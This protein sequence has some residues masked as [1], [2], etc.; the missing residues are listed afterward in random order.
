LQTFSRLEVWEGDAAFLA[1][2]ARARASSR[3]GQDFRLIEFLKADL[4]ICHNPSIP[5]ALLRS[6]AP[7]RYDLEGARQ[8][9]RITL[10]VAEILVVY[11]VVDFFL[12]LFYLEL[13]HLAGCSH[14]V[15]LVNLFDASFGD[16]L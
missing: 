6:G 16:F 3:P 2:T 5:R 15:S 7:L 11:A 1:N 13:A 8:H 12:N 10:E 4:L 14:M 9:G